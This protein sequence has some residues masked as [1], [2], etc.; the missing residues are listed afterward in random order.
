MHF[1]NCLQAFF[2]PVKI[3]LSIIMCQQESLFLS[4]DTSA[5]FKSAITE[6]KLE[7]TI[8]YY[9]QVPPCLSFLLPFLLILVVGFLS[10]LT[11]IRL[12]L[13]F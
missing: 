2:L 12:S 9:S 3:A 5:A 10:C 4:V 11:R 1:Q 6:G 8:C 7:I 13:L